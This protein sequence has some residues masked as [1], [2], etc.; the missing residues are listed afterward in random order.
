MKHYLLTWTSALIT[1]LGAF[2]LS[3]DDT[4]PAEPPTVERTNFGWRAGDCV[5]TT[6]LPEGYPAPTAPGAIEVKEYPVVRKAQVT[7]DMNIAAG[8]NAGFWV[9][10]RHIKDRDIAMTSPV[11]MD[12]HGWVGDKLVPEKWTMAFLYRTA[13]LGPTGEAGQVEVVDSEPMSVVSLGLR[14]AY[15]MQN[16]QQAMEKLEVWLA[17]HP[18]WEVAGE[19]RSLAYNGPNVRS[20]RRWSEMQVPIQPVTPEADAET[21]AAASG[22]TDDAATGGQTDGAV[23]EEDDEPADG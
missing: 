10:F 22:D 23:A 16:Y 18:Q 15:T 13:D 17:E 11:E 19:P 6:S 7:S 8:R 4:Q 12:Y 1:G 20:Y 2:T 9:L 3:D 21:E 5:I 14:G